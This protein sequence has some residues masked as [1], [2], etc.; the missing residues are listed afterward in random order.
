M[1]LLVAAHPV[2]VKV[3]VAVKHG[4]DLGVA[5]VE[6]LVVVGVVV[7]NGSLITMDDVVLVEDLEEVDDVLVGQVAGPVI[8]EVLVAHP[9]G[10]TVGQGRVVLV[11]EVF[12][13]VGLGPGIVVEVRIRQAG[14]VHAWVAVQLFGVTVLVMV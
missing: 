7:G 2:G 5:V 1:Q 3:L 14:V 12:A 13:Q 6:H 11:V 10:Q 9:V 8:V 4:H